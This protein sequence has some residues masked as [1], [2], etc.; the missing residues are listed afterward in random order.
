[1]GNFIQRIFNNRTQLEQIFAEEIC[2]FLQSE[3][4]ELGAATILLSGGST[5]IDLYKTLSK[6]DIDWEKVTVGLIDERFVSTNSKDSNEKLIRETFLQNRA[7]KANFI[8]LIFNQDNYEKNLKLATTNNETFFNS[9]TCSL[10]GMGKDG[11]TASLFP[12]PDVDYTNDILFG[13]KNIINTTSNTT[14]I[15]RISYTKSALL[16]SKHLFLYFNGEEKINVF[17]SAKNNTN[18]TIFPIS[19]F[20]HQKC[21][22]LNVY[23]SL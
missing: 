12:N 7:A 6:I 21:N 16:R 17:Q 14:P 13:A 5:P 11:H 20:I 23:C 19:S 3:I 10:L 15:K 18:C 22:V 4:N 8:G 1:M 9:I 2:H